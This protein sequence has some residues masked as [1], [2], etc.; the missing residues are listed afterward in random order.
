MKTRQKILLHLIDGAPGIP[1][2]TALM[3]WLFLL[4]QE[5]VLRKW[6]TFYDF[7]PYR[8]GPF[9]FTV[10]QD[11][12]SLV[13]SGLVRE[14]A[15]SVALINGEQIKK[16]VSKVSKE[17]ETAVELVLNK[18][19]K[20]TTHRLITYVY[21]CF[22]WYASRSKKMPAVSSGKQGKIAIHTVSYEGVSIDAF[23]NLL[24]R[25]GIH[26]VI[27]VRKNAISRKFG[28]S[29]SRLAEYCRKIEID[30]LHF[31]QLGVPSDMRKLL[32]SK[33]I[34]YPNFFSSYSHNI[35]AKQWPALAQL[36]KLVSEIPSA[37]MC[38][39]ADPS[40]CHRHLIAKALSES[41]NLQIIHHR[42]DTSVREKEGSDNREDLS[43]SV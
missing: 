31:P 39:E 10:Y 9:S 11:L 34:S 6:D 3:K 16:E 5:T 41:E 17:A 8:Y 14:T 13:S 23:L 27:D 26:R 19:G 18:Y 20:W 22:P 35:L 36:G 33:R 28:F 29:K 15:D 25:N 37:I 1:H 12:R 24:L 2:K 32:T 4:R 7:L 40:L 38:F 42:G 30:Y 21:S 43:C